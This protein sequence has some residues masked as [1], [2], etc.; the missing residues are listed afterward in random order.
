MR[1]LDVELVRRGIVPSRTAARRLLDAGEVRV[2]SVTAA[3]PSMLVHGEDVIDVTD[4]ALLHFVSRA[5]GKLSGALDALAQTPL[6]GPR[7]T[8][9]HALDVGASTGGFTQVLLERGA[10]SV[11]ALDVG[12]DQLDQRIRED[13]R[14]R[15]LE[16]TNIREV[17]PG[18]LHPPPDLVA[19]DLS[20]I[21]LRLVVEPIDR[22]L[23]EQADVMLLI[24]PQFEVGRARL[25]SGGIVTDPAG[26]R[27]AIRGV[28]DAA[29]HVGWRLRALGPSSVAGMHG[30]REFIAW[31]Q[32]QRPED[33]TLAERETALV[34]LALN[35]SFGIA[36]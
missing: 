18:T 10:A 8:G 36:E 24:K 25:G 30:N 11:V 33:D 21:S 4:P 6:G 20:F 34:D 31:W 13:P 22:L 3:K 1:R 32:R 26:H 23:A 28:L 14:V 15:V 19:G 16:R 5:A 12:H 9:R 2:N 7:P 27:A 35:G 29:E 17:P